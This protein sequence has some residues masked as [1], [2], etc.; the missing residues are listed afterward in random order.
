LE[1]C[2]GHQD[3]ANGTDFHKSTG[4]RPDLSDLGRCG[5]RGNGTAG[6]RA[7]ERKGEGT[8]EKVENE[9]KG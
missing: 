9:R 5:G 1:T 2:A 4:R 6:G 7:G 3:G 8:G